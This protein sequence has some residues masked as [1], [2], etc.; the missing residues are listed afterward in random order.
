MISLFSALALIPR[1]DTVRGPWWLGAHLPGWL[2]MASI[3][4]RFSAIARV[5]LSKRHNC[6]YI[7]RTH[8][9]YFPQK[10]YEPFAVC[11]C[12]LYTTTLFTWKKLWLLPCSAIW[13]NFPGLCLILYLSCLIGMVVYAFYST[14]DPFSF[15]LVK[16]SDQVRIK[17]WEE[18]YLPH[19]I[20][21]Y[22]PVQ[23]PTC[24]QGSYVFVLTA[25]TELH[26]CKIKVQ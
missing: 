23:V 21:L 18:S 2:S 24:C 19:G 25:N 10:T 1:S 8:S 15:H 17:C 13:L 26:T 3:R 5:L 4:H 11:I 6:E 12:I 7:F 20:K 9:A 16:T 14:C 22:Q